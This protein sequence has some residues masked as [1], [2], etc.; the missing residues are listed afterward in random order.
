MTPRTLNF[1]FSSTMSDIVKSPFSSQIACFRDILND[2]PPY[3]CGT[4][5]VRGSQL[6]L[7]YGKEVLNARRLDFSD[8]TDDQLEHLSATC[9]PA[10]FG[11]NREN[12][13][14]ERYR[15]A[16]KLD[17]THF[18][19]CFDV[20]E[21]DLITIICDNLLRGRQVNSDIQLEKY[22]LN[23]YGKDSFFKP[24]KDTPR[25]NNMFGSLVLMLPTRHE[26][27]ALVLRDGDKEWTFDSAKEMQEHDGPCLAYAAFYGDVD[28]E[29]LPVIAGYRVTITY[30]LYFGRTARLSSRDPTQDI[31]HDNLKG[32][33]Q[34]LLSDPSFLPKGGYLG[35]GLGRQYPLDWNSDLRDL[36]QYLKGDDAAL[37]EVCNELSLDASLRLYVDNEYSDNV[38]ILCKNVPDLGCEEIEDLE[39]HLCGS[40]GALRVQARELHPDEDYRYWDTKPDIVIHWAT[41]VTVFGDILG[42][43][44]HYGNEASI[45]YVYG[46][47]CLIVAIGP[48][49]SRTDSSKIDSLKELAAAL[50]EMSTSNWILQLFSWLSLHHYR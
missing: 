2:K 31:R 19:F 14:D 34:T 9:E 33:F 32:A 4:L 50:A 13:I 29:V 40:N 5:S 41:P 24:H 44:A 48:Y 43:Y 47:V 22:K 36:E 8:V 49:D 12:V 16:G 38:D 15:K 35:F 23:V 30:N 25:G 3:C 37:M 20:P 7:F 46:C 42:P 6:I 45:S 39:Y 10:A 11:L 27:G 21:S 18:A 28:H 1:L 26:G 17:A